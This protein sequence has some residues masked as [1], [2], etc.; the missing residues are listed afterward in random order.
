MGSTKAFAQSFSLKTKPFL[1]PSQNFSISL[2]FYVYCLASTFE[3][4]LTILS[5]DE[6]NQVLSGACWHPESV[7]PMLT[8]RV[9]RANDWWEKALLP[10]CQNR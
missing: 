1:V 8:L 5:E 4:D 6:M 9:L 10:G 3:Q 7:D 2:L